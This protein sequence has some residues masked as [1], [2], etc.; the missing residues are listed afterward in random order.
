V[1]HF[2]KLDKNHLKMDKFFL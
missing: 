1:I 2:N